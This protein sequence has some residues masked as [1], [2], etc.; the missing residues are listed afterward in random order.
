M[1]PIKIQ[2]ILYLLLGR[3]YGKSF[4]WR[5][6]GSANLLVQGVKTSVND[7]DIATDERGFKWFKAYF[8]TDGKA[9][10][11]QQTKSYVINVK[12]EEVAIEINCYD[13]LELRMFDKVRLQDWEGLT[14][15]VL[16]LPQAAFFYHKIGRNSKVNLIKSSPIYL[17]QKDM[18]TIS[19][20]KYV[21]Y[22]FN[23]INKKIDQLIKTDYE[24]DRKKVK[25]ELM[26]LIAELISD[27]ILDDV[28]FNKKMQTISALNPDYLK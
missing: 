6:D 23:F 26:N 9:S 21:K 11:N 17:K 15:P 5:L 4:K 28:T 27:T 14:I 10:Y 2:D 18:S 3:L 16:P 24:S 19:K 12:H 8:E 7:V 20:E 13:D 22:K 1:T 25:P